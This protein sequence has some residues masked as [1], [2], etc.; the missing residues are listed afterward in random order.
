MRLTSHQ[1]KIFKQVCGEIFGLEAHLLLFGSRVDDQ[2]RGGDIDLY[3]VG[4]DRPIT[5]QLE[6]KLRFLTKVKRELGEQRIDLV[7]A[8]A[9]EQPQAPIHRLAERTGVPL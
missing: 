3:V 1:I 5:E 6:T 4:F 8:P 2:Q 9:P 7:F